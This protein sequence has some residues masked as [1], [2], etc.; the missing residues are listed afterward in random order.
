MFYFTLKEEA[1]R[2][3]LDLDSAEPSVRLLAEY[4]RLVPPLFERLPWLTC[5]PGCLR[6][7]EKVYE[8]LTRVC[9]CA[10]PDLYLL[11]FY[12]LSYRWGGKAF[13]TYIHLW[14]VVESSNE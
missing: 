10:S 2:A 13:T 4:F 8:R 9:G 6:W 3:L 12:F 5:W 11:F 14:R 1:A 7:L